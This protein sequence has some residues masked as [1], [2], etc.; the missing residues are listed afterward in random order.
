MVMSADQRKLTSVEMGKLWITYAGNTMSQCIFKYY[1]QHVEDA[2]IKKVVEYALNLSESILASIKEIYE[3]TG[4]P[5]PIGMTE[6]DVNIHAPRLFADEFYL[7]YLRYVGKTGLSIYSIAVPLVMQNDIRDLFISWLNSTVELS[8][9]VN[10]LLQTKGLYVQP[11]TLP[12]PE[13]VTFID[14]QSYLRGFLGDTRPLHAMEITHLHNNMDNNVTSK[15]LLTAF[16]QTARDEK[17][18][19]FFKRGE[20]IAHKHIE[21]CSKQLSDEDLPGAPLIDHLIST[22]TTPPFSDKLMLAHKIDMFSMKIRSYG[23]GASLNGRRDIGAMYAK[24]L[25]DVSLYVEDGANL[26]ID[27]GWMERPPSAANR[28][29]LNS[30]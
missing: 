30:E 24:F 19:D 10:D 9:M 15:A 25:L 23:N 18:R 27:M 8:N 11:P 13:R 20:K 14:K 2:E 1:L 12:I 26:M 28:K 22:S 17:V 6:E 4:F 21:S 5:V 16:S 3:E 7:F 29:H